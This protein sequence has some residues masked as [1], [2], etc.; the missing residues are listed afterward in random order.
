ME[1]MILPYKH[2]KDCC[3]CG[4]C[5]LVCPHGA[6]TMRTDEEGFVYPYVNEEKCVSCGL[7]EKMCAFQNKRETNEPIKVYALARKDAISLKKSAS[8]GAF[9]G[10]A[11]Q[12]IEQGGVV[13]GASL[14]KCNGKLVPC[15]VSAQKKEDLFPLLGS[16]YVQSDLG[17]TFLETKEL[18][19]HGRKVLFS[20]TPCQIAALK[21]WLRKD[22]SELLTIDLVCHGVPNAVMFQD[23][24]EIE[25]KKVG[26]IAEDFRF[27]DKEMGWGLNAKLIYSNNSEQHSVCIPSHNSSFYE[28]FLRGEIYRENCYSCPYANSHRPGDMTI[29]DYWGIEKQHPEYLKPEGT[30]DCE[31]G[32]SLLIINTKK[33]AE[34]FEKFGSVFK[35]YPSIFE[36]AA[37]YNEQL[38]NPSQAGSNRS[39]I[40][41]LYRDKGY[42]AVDRWFINS[43]KK[44]KIKEGILYHIHNDI[45]E[46]VRNIVK[47]IVRR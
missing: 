20:G 28:L 37:K 5:A 12:W 27:R 32:V 25:S 9:A 7:C 6:I 18:L 42:E 21:N 43:E 45:P 29:G 30:L 24:I 41:M 33:G 10:L 4:V 1:K 38:N 16:K 11:E 2:K 23:Y 34:A 40:L 13:F 46:P 39:K 19:E 17:Q 22:Y 26:H 8:G 44:E 14:R 15:H 35:Y 36:K 31:E 47:K 3:A